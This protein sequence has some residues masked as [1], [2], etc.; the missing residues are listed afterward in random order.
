ML[1]VD[2]G[3]RYSYRNQPSICKWNCSKLAESI[4]MYLPMSRAK[5]AYEK[6]DDIYQEHYLNKMRK[7]LGFFKA[8]EDDA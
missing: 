2:N 6:F 3:G 1:C 7:K 4:K 8:S 5:E